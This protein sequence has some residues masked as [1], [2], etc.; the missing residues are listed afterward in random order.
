MPAGGG[1]CSSIV[2]RKR[3]SKSYKQQYHQDIEVNHILPSF[4]SIKYFFKITPRF[5]ILDRGDFFRGSFRQ[6]IPAAFAPFGAEVDHPIGRFHNVE[7][8]LNHDHGVAEIDQSE[9][10]VKQVADIM[11]VKPRGRFVK[12]VK[13]FSRFDFR[14]FGRELDPLGFTAGKRR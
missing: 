2:V 8:M 6:K 9:K 10:N 13:R 11:R 12:Y 7:I 14:K 1:T 4:V 5:I 3:L